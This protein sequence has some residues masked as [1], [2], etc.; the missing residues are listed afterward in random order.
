MWPDEPRPKLHYPLTIP[1]SLM[2]MLSSGGEDD[3]GS[4]G[5]RVGWVADV[6][7]H[8][9]PSPQKM[10]LPPLLSTLCMVPG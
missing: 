1:L 8:I 6:V 9:P 3:E 4:Y 7:A 2:R 10:C 5:G